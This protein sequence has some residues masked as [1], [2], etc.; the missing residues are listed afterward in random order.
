ML[1]RSGKGT[2]RARKPASTEK[3]ESSESGGKGGRCQR[4]SWTLAPL[5]G[6][7]SFGFFPGTG[8]CANGMEVNAMEHAITRPSQAGPLALAALAA[9]FGLYVLALDQGHLLSL[10]Q[11]ATAFD[12]NLIHELVHDARHAA[13]F[14]CH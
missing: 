6:R 3:L 8:G 5:G 13:G 11:G 9:L 4:S 14:P 2:T 12:V 7:G 10:V 1:Y